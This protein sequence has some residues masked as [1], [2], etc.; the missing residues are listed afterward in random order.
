[1][2]AILGVIFHFIGGFASGSFYIPYKKVKGWAWESYWIIGGLFSWLIVPPLAAWLTIPD[3][4]SIIS[5]T[6]F[7]VL[8]WTFIMGV[9]WGIGG[10]TYGLG[11]RY[12]GVSLGS[13]IILGLCSVFGS[14]VPS[15]YYDV[16]PTAGKDTIT[17]LFSQR[18]GQFVLLGLLVCVIGIIIC[19]KAGAMKDRDL[20]GQQTTEANKEF[21]IGL[22]LLVAIISGVL[23]A[24][25]SFGIEA[26]SQMAS[27]ANEH[28]KAAHPGE[29]EFLYRN[30]VV[31]V[32]LL[33]GGLTT[34]F[35]WCMILNARN[36][37]FKNYTDGKSPLARNYLFSALAGT[38][39]FLQFFF[40]GMGE[41]KLGN[42]ASS[43]ILHMAFIILV[44]NAWG[45][46]LNE[47]KGVSR[48]TK[49]AIIIGILV[50]LASVLIVGYGNSLKPDPATTLRQDTERPIYRI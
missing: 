46:V 4:G 22:G 43:W 11:V 12:L 18:W 50:I 9:L 31:Y 27:V 17:D 42:G 47:W 48:K 10:L 20:A 23:S 25:F 15:I 26:G 6:D 7:S 16:F 28:W 24:C 36:K 32:V 45:L 49:N 33:W 21:K 14:L 39:W 13:S 41:S 3:F 37:T 38:T 34:N 2:G 1:M 40:Y 44:A 29:G 8:K 5:S 35:I 30:N 19:G